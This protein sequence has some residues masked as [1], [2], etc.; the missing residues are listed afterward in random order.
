MLQ[1]FF[2]NG[3]GFYKLVD[4]TCV[5]KWEG[6]GAESVRAVEALKYFHYM[7]DSCAAG[8]LIYS[9][10]CGRSALDASFYSQSAASLPPDLP[11]QLAV[12]L[13]DG[14][15]SQGALQV[16]RGLLN[17]KQEHRTPIAEVLAH[18]WVAHG[19]PAY[20]AE[21]ARSHE[22]IEAARQADMEAEAEREYQRAMGIKV[23]EAPA[24]Q[25]STDQTQ[26][27]HDGLVLGTQA[28]FDAIAAES[29]RLQLHSRHLR[30]NGEA[31]ACEAAKQEAE[32][33]KKV[34]FDAV[35][36]SRQ[37]ALQGETKAAAKAESEQRE[38]EE[39]KQRQQKVHRVCHV[40]SSLPG[41]RKKQRLQ[42]LRKQP[43]R[44]QKQLRKQKNVVSSIVSPATTT[45]E[46]H[47]L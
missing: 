46:L 20:V 4:L 31:Q 23:E 7:C 33:A 38:A 22:A 16:L 10:L 26:K 29:L 18:D 40:S 37:G 14:E 17:A 12:D 30:E 34:K 21:K 5:K 1:V 47:T 24:E 11:A 3:A 32:E 42:Q 39:A 41:C 19:G 8:N 28:S 13:T 9:L 36:A 6:E 45:I 27:T 25:A 2:V 43:R 35:L 44:Q 15:L